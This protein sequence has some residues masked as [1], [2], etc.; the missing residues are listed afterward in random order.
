M[1]FFVTILSPA[2][3]QGSVRTRDRWNG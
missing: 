3:S 2:T 1:F